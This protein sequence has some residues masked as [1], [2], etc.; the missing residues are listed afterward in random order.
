MSFRNPIHIYDDTY[1]LTFADVIIM[2]DELDKPVLLYNTPGALKQDS[3][4]I[5]QFQKPLG[6]RLIHDLATGSILIG[7]LMAMLYIR[8]AY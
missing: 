7:S 8:N 1:Y 2:A 6:A 3:F 5:Y 4:Q